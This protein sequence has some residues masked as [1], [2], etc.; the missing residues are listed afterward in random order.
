LADRLL[1][2]GRTSDSEADG[3]ELGDGEAPLGVAAGDGA[4][5][6]GAASGVAIDAGLTA[7]VVSGVTVAAGV[8]GVV[9]DPG[10]AELEGCPPDGAA[11]CCSHPARRRLE[12]AR[13]TTKL[14]IMP[15][16]TDA[17]GGGIFK[18]RC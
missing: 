3:E 8:A 11:G 16:Y 2:V 12:K 13:A 7:G 9:L 17:R 18:P 6:A 5:V 14:L 4:G 10:L 15:R 1:S